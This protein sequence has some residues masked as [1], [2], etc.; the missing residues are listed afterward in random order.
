MKMS[1][2]EIG[3]WIVILLVVTFFSFKIAL[4]FNHKWTPPEF[5]TEVYKD[6]QAFEGPP[7]P[8]IYDHDVK[9]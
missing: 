2:K 5:H 8:V 4:Y 6:D 3:V 1:N 9:G 7:S